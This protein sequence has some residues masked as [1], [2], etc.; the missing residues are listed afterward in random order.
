MT[1]AIARRPQRG[2]TLIEL[3]VVIAIIAILAAILFP[4][5]QKVRE[6]ARRTACLSNLKQLGLGFTQYMQDADEQFPI[7]FPNLSKGCFAA[8]NGYPQGEAWAFQI[9]PFVKSTGVYICPDD[10]TPQT[11]GLVS[12]AFNADLADV[13]GKSLSQLAAPSSTVMLFEAPASTAANQGEDPSQTLAGVTQDCYMASEDPDGEPFYLATPPASASGHLGGRMANTLPTRHDPGSNFLE[14]DGHVK[15]LRP[16]QVSSGATTPFGAN[17]YQ[18]QGG[19]GQYLAATTD[20][21]NL[22]ATSGGPKA[23]VTFSPQ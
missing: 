19:A 10:S 18:D 7:G 5:F 22:T 14:T 4:V 23:Q 2:F 12:Y 15:Y 20:N 16:T 1:V 17:R 21:M 8:T 3:L 13:A 11:Y 9:Y 6:N